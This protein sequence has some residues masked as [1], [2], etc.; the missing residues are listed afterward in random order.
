MVFHFLLSLSDSKFP[1]V[2]RIF[3]NIQA[4]FN[5]VVVWMV[6]ARPSIS[7]SSKPFNKHLGIVSRTPITI[8]IAFTLMFQIFFSSLARS[9]YFSLFSFSFMF[10]QWS[11]GTAKSTIRQVVF[12]IY[13]LII[14]RSGLLGGIK[15]SICISKSQRIFCVAFSRTDSD[16]C[17]YHLVV[18]SNFKLLHNSSFQPSRV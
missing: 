8:D 13:S 10:A 6:F 11:A 3:L 5:N 9:K 17:I 16:L 2:S 7:D 12:F 15:W 4:E 14:T 1:Q 18:W